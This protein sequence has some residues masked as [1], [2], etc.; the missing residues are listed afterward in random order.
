MKYIFVL[1]VGFIFIVCQQKMTIELT[2]IDGLVYV[3]VYKTIIINPNEDIKKP[4]YLLSDKT[5]YL[6]D[7]KNPIR[8]ISKDVK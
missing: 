3:D 5:L 2:C 8:C 7:N 1:L 4:Q 6:D